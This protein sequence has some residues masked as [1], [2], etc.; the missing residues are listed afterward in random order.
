MNIGVIGVG[1][2][3]REVVR[4]LLAPKHAVTIWNRSRERTRIPSLESR[5]LSCRLEQAIFLGSG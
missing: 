3:G 4:Q 2:M 5:S 1:K